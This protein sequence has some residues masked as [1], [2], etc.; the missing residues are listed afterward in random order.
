MCNT[1]HEALERALNDYVQVSKRLME[2]LNLHRIS[3]QTALPDLP[4][5]AEPALRSQVSW[6]G[7]YGQGALH[8]SSEID[9]SKPPTT[10]RNS[11]RI[12]VAGC[13]G[14]KT[15]SQECQVPLFK[16]GSTQVDLLQ[17]LAELDADRYAAGRRLQHKTISDPGFDRW[18]LMTIDYNLPRAPDSPVWVEPRSLCVRLGKSLTASQFEDRLRE[19]LGPI[20]LARWLK[21]DEGQNHFTTLGLDPSRAERYTPYGYGESV[22]LSRADE[23]YLFRHRLDM[24]RLCRLIEQIVG[25]TMPD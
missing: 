25:E 20:S 2:V 16:I 14:L 24:P 23:I 8:R 15:L 10:S 7:P 13:A 21:T 19:A 6:P 17:R 4:D 1:K 22:R 12:Y 11:T 9:I 3:D 18:K 5:T